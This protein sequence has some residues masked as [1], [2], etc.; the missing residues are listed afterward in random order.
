MFGGGQNPTF[1]KCLTATRALSVA[2]HTLC[3]VLD[4]LTKDLSRVAAC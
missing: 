1:G 3:S 4:A 2:W